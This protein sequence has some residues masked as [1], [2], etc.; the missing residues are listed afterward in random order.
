MPATRPTNQKLLV[1]HRD[2]GGRQIEISPISAMIN[3]LPN[4]P[5]IMKPRDVFN[6]AVRI[7]GLVFL[8]HGLSAMPA[9]V[10]HIVTF[11]F[12]GLFINTLQ[13][14]WPLVLAYWL[15][16]GASQLMEI[17]YPDGDNGNNFGA[18]IVKKTD[19]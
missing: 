16:G 13:I 3:K 15:I 11:N 18:T 9:I 10:T 1:G 4:K 7:L 12:F 2:A 14:A 19:V 17:A 6:I 8:Y 5:N